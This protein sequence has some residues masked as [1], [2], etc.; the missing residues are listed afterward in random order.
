M[1]THAP[2]TIDELLP[3]LIAFVKENKEFEKAFKHWA[4]DLKSSGME[5]PVKPLGPVLTGEVMLEIVNE[6][7]RLRSVA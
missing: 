5:K 7:I 2:V 4:K 6:I 1:S 3:A